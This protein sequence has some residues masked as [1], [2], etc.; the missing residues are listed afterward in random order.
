MGQGASRSNSTKHILNTKSS[1]KKDLVEIDY[2]ISP[3]IWSGYLLAEQ[4]Y[5]FIDNICYQDNQ[6]TMKLENNG[7]E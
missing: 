2:E 3:M 4:G 7:R 6:S 1:T 5:Q